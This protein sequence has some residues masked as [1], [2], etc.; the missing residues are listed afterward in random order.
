VNIIP[1]GDGDD[2]PCRRCQRRQAGECLAIPAGSDAA[3]DNVR[4][5]TI[6]SSSKYLKREHGGTL[7]VADEASS[8]STPPRKKQKKS[9]LTKLV[10]TLGSLLEADS[11]QEEALAEIA[12]D[13]EQLQEINRSNEL[14][15]QELIFLRQ[16]Q[17][18]NP[19][20]NSTYCPLPYFVM[21]PVSSFSYW[22]WNS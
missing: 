12:N 14:K 1:S 2:S 18:L 15:L 8:L 3:G 22:V 17:Q 16:S 11:Q 9:T 6:S 10:Q 21:V 7:S 19:T 5:T 4:A 13:L 20:S